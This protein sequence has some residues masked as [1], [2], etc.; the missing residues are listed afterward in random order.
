MTELTIYNLTEYCNKRFKGKTYGELRDNAARYREQL[1]DE[2]NIS[3]DFKTHFDPDNVMLFDGMLGESAFGNIHDI[4]ERLHYD[5]GEP[6]S[7]DDYNFFDH[8]DRI[9]D[10][11]SYFNNQIVDCFI[12]D[13]EQ[14]YIRL[15][16]TKAELDDDLRADYDGSSWEHDFGKTEV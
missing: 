13:G 3:V 11:Y 12:T 14:L 7:C 6:L 16:Y 1:L 10:L 9:D 2:S 5:N 4:M 8:Y 15:W